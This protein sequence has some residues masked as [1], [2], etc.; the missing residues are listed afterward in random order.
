MTTPNA[1]R[2]IAKTVATSRA[3]TDTKVTGVDSLAVRY[4][5]RWFTS[6]VGN[7]PSLE[8]AKNKLAR[9]ALPRSLIVIGPYGSGKT[10]VSRIIAQSVTCTEPGEGGRPCRMCD[11]CKFFANVTGG[12]KGHPD[13]IELNCSDKTGVDD[14]RQVLASIGARPL[15]GR[16]RVVHLDEV[17]KLSESAKNSLLKSF[18]EPPPH[19]YIILSTMEPERFYNDKAGTAIKSRGLEIITPHPTVAEVAGHL[20][21]IANA[22]KQVLDQSIYKMIAQQTGGIM[23]DAIKTLDFVFDAD[24]AALKDIT[25]AEAVISKVVGKSPFG[26]AKNALISFYS[27]DMA[28]LVTALTEFENHQFIVKIMI[29]Q[30][31]EAIKHRYAPKTVDARAAWAARDIAACKAGTMTMGKLGLKL[32]EIQQHGYVINAGHSLINLLASSIRE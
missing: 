6:V 22:E 11:S 16:H 14:M 9:G 1:P 8:S 20:E 21:R 18:E 30:N 5:S 2:K 31:V 25:K 15:I 4:R 29:E 28:G 13:V 32:Q 17:Q 12:A 24:P 7:S 27:S 23:R 26:V 3:A 10:T 19:T